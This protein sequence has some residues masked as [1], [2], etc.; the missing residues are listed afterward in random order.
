MME[1]EDGMM[2]WQTGLTG[3]RKQ[4][5]GRERGEAIGHIGHKSQQTHSHLV[6]HMMDGMEDGRW[7]NW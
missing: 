1:M 2:G 4:E 5:S 7:E 3:S 6:D